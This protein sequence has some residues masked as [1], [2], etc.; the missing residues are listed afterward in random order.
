LNINNS[1]IK[2]KEDKIE[3]KNDKKKYISVAK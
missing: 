1:I 2:E 3:K